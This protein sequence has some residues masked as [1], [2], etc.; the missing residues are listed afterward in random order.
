MKINIR[1]S[2]GTSLGQ[3]SGE[4]NIHRNHGAHEQLDSDTVSLGQSSDSQ[5]AG[6]V[7]QSMRLVLS[8]ATRVKSNNNTQGQ[9]RA[10]L[11]AIP[12]DDAGR[13]D[14]K[15]IVQTQKRQALNSA[16]ERLMLEGLGASAERDFVSAVDRLFAEYADNL[17]LSEQEVD[18]AREVMLSEVKMAV[19]TELNIKPWNP[20]GTLEGPTNG[21]EAAIAAVQ[22]KLNAR[23][24]A[25]MEAAGDLSGVL[26]E[27]TVDA[28][29]D[30]PAATSVLG[31]F[32]IRFNEAVEARSTQN[33]KDRARERLMG[34][35]APANL[36]GQHANTGTS[37]L[38]LL[39]AAG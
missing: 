27:L 35:N 31:D 6:P 26:A 9:F 30:E 16:V 7:N 36:D 28:Q 23:R 18:M 14:P 3:Y 13:Y 15:S 20:Y 2:M 33:L 22:N 19:K 38:G 5:S 24:Q 21:Q 34:A 39:R 12:K 4:R 10:A 37:F 11:R 32:L 1:G 17:G 8:H 25:L 29:Q